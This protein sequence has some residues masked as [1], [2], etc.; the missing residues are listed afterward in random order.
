MSILELISIFQVSENVYKTCSQQIRFR[1]FT[2]V[3]EYSRTNL[4]SPFKHSATR[5]NIFINLISR[6][7][8][9]FMIKN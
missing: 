8:S 1:I 4:N 3:F 2:N 9:V 7:F 5:F 6:F